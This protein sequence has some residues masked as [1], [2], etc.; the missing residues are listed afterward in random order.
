M[1]WAVVEVCTTF[2]EV[3]TMLWAMLDGSIT[4]HCALAR[5]ARSRHRQ[6]IIVILVLMFTLDFSGCYSS[7]WFSGCGFTRT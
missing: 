2:L 5:P 7:V 4:A 1:F 6:T 3:F